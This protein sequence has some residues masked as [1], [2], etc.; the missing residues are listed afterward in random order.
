MMS[1][2]STISA[3]LY[4]KS[5]QTCE[6]LTDPWS[7]GVTAEPPTTSDEHPFKLSNLEQWLL[8]EIHENIIKVAFFIEDDIWALEHDICNLQSFI[9]CKFGKDLINQRYLSWGF[10]GF[11]S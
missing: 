1:M 2:P 9:F 8:I 5:V 10:Q 4:L 3:G 11:I 7:N 6:K